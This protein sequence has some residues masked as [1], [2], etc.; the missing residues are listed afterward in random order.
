MAPELVQPG[1]AA[2]PVRYSWLYLTATL[3]A[4]LAPVPAISAPLAAGV[5]AAT[6]PADA[7][8]R[9]APPRRHCV[10]PGCSRTTLTFAAPECGDEGC[11]Q[12]EGEHAQIVPRA[13]SFD[14]VHRQ[15]GVGQQP[16]CAA[17]QRG[18]EQRAVP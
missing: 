2:L 4:K 17:E 1:E 6:H 7:L 10:A 16:S 5:Y 9:V 12:Q 3:A 18:G 13:E 11:R 8:L 14:G 15:E